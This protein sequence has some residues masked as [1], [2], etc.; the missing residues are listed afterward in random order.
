MYQKKECSFNMIFRLFM[1]DRFIERLAISEYKDNFILKGGFY[2]SILFG[3]ENRMTMD[4]DASITKIDFNE[5]NI[6]I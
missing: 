6:K 4:I 3:V 2:L 5:E 1:Y